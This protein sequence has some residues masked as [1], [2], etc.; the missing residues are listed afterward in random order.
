MPIILLTNSYSSDVLD[1]VRKELPNGFEFTSL[2]YARKEDLLKK[3][4][5]ADYF[6]ASGRVS[7]DKDIVDSAVNLKMIQRTGVGTDAL[8]LE[9]LRKKKIPVYL[10]EGVNSTSVAEH[11]IMLMLATLRNLP[12]VDCSVKS[13]KWLKNDFGINSRSLEGKTVG[14]IGLGHI[15]MSVAN[16]LKPFGVSVKYYKRT[17]LRPESESQIQA[18]YCSLSELISTSDIISLHCP[19]TPE[20]K[21]MMGRE[22]F[23]SMK[24]EAIIINTSRGGMI[25]EQVLIEYLKYGRIRGAGLDVYEGEPIAA[26]NRLRSL[27]NVVLTPHIGGLTLETFSKMIRK[28]FDN[29]RLFEEGNLNSIE[30]NK[31]V[32]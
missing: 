1:I 5:Y 29:I 22:E 10:N 28:A 19:L 24:E 25:H 20:T 6:L 26:T 3:S 8:D 9:Y 15:G 31:L 7:I 14:L 4:S 32:I 16:L 30:E 18:K 27:E 21:G 23:A 11:T 17:R 12:V 2:D 13:G